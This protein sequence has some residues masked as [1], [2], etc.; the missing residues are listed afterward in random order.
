MNKNTTAHFY[1]A[2]NFDWEEQSN[3]LEH[4]CCHAFADLFSQECAVD[5]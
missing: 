3:W 5:Y 2:R 1:L 4:L